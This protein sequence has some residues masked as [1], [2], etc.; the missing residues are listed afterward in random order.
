MIEL[1]R[2]LNPLPPDFWWLSKI[3]FATHFFIT[4]ELI[5]NAEEKYP[6]NIIII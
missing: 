3:K 5:N 2:I 4:F 1:E 6:G